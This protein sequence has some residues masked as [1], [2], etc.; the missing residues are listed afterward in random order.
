M[1]STLKKITA[2]LLAALFLTACQ[3]AEK[4]EYQTQAP[5]FSYENATIYFA[6]TDRF[7]DGDP[8]KN[9]SYGRATVDSHGKDIGTFHGGD[10]PGLTK[11]LEEGYF[12][13]LGVNA[14]WITAPYEQIHGYIGGGPEGDFAHYAFHGYYAV[15]WTMM[16]RSMGTVEEF[17][18]FVD[19]AHAQGIRVIMDVV[20][21]HVGY[22]NLQD[23]LDFGYGN[24]TG[25]AEEHA[26]EAEETFFDY[27]KYVDYRDAEAFQNFYGDWVRADL[28]GYNP[29]GNT[30]ITMALAGLPDV[31][32]EVQ[33]N[34]GLAPLLATKWA[35]EDQEDEPWIVP[36]AKKY[37]QELPLSPAGYISAWL[38]AWV[39][40]F[41]IDG[42]RIDTAKHVEVERW[43]ELKILTSSAL[44]TY[45]EKHPES[46]AA[47]FT[48]DF[49]FMGEVWGH[50]VL[51]DY[52]FDNG[53]DA[54]INF[55]FQGLKKDG[56]AFLKKNQNSVYQKYAEVLNT[57][58]D[59]NVVSYISQ[60]DT[61]LYPREK[62]MKGGTD[63]LLLPGAVMVFYGDETAR[64]MGDGGSD[65]TQGTRSS[66]NWDSID[67]KVLQH[68]QKLGS[69]RNRNIA[70]GAGEHKMLSEEP[71]VFQRSYDRNGVKN[72]VLVYQGAP[73]AVTLSVEG[74]FAE[75]SF[76][77]DA[78]TGSVM[79]VKDGKIA[80]TV[81]EAG[82]SL[83]E[84]VEPVK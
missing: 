66:M 20:M 2:A 9:N 44:K 48:E 24:V 58:E 19:T 68:F 30:E 82:L 84:A 21:N 16:D 42:F 75:G 8:S 47:K 49:F 56:P 41:G 38:S 78:Y 60:H 23:M 6:M 45:R 25:T 18:T 53:F 33:D 11:K 71:Y 14:I 29:P 26:V 34:L 5:V 81:D 59:F 1:N 70:V 57:D 80:L 65:P 55:T 12:E 22:P 40:E 28:P 36:A 79:T 7:Y 27:K 72:T 3:G 51:K 37:R 13:K 69:F 50:G 63:L 64:P 67:E 43:K 61:N 10:I 83:L 62:L 76:V 46:P 32:T 54:L 77:R 35:Q 39:E 17:R 15:D 73:G 4:E 31:R 52:Y 74:A